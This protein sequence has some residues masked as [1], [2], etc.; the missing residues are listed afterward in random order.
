MNTMDSFEKEGF[1]IERDGKVITLSSGEMSDFR[2]LE[3][4]L[5]GRKCLEYF[6]AD[7]DEEKV[8]EKMKADEEICHNIGDDVLEIL[9]SD[10]EPVEYD[11]IKNYIDRNRK[12]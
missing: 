10:A 3:E 1:K 12:G 5:Y 8:I 7:E 11:V 4:A 2:Y 9:Y 6:N